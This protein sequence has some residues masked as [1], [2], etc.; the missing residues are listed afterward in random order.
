MQGT[1]C[2]WCQDSH[3]LHIGDFLDWFVKGIGRWNQGSDRYSKG[4]V[5][6]FPEG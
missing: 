4:S 3:G 5:G 1:V 2:G 6:I